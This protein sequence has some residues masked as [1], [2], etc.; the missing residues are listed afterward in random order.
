MVRELIAAAVAAPVVG[1]SIWVGYAYLRLR[2]YNRHKRV[3][4]DVLPGGFLRYT[5]QE[6]WAIASLGWW[7]LRAFFSDAVRHPKG[8]PAGPPVLCVHGITQ[9]GTN[10]W[11]IRRALEKRGRA[12]RAVSLGWPGRR[13]EAYAPALE[14]A[15]RSLLADPR[16]TPSGTVDVVAHSM[17][18]LV[19]RVVLAEHADLAAR[20][21]RIV[22][23]G[24]PH[25]GTAGARGLRWPGELHGLG[26]RSSWIRD[27]PGLETSAPGA[28]LTTIAALDDL[29]VYPH[30]TCH[31]PGARTVD[32]PGIGHAGL[33]A[34]R[35]AIACVVD[36]LCAPG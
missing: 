8:V 30:H 34:H 1:L 4:V 20:V 23:L 15:L 32:L 36:A 9:N 5:L 27:L 35:Q 28:S 7:H 25:Q 18:G 14:R 10:L 17:G 29:I 6:A 2:S 12:T 24:C 31:I 3:P 22:T 33:I 19:L 13:I 26:R 11:G 21:R 16:A